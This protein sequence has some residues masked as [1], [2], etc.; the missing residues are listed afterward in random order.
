MAW[1]NLNVRRIGLPVARCISCD[2]YIWFVTFNSDILSL[3]TKCFRASQPKICCKA[4]DNSCTG[5]TFL[6]PQISA[7]LGPYFWGMAIGALPL[8]SHETHF[9]LPLTIAFWKSVRTS[10]PAWRIH[11]QTLLTGKTEVIDR[12]VMTTHFEG[13]KKSLNKQFSPIDS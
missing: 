13:K 1:S 2:T 12:K 6:Q 8:D 3:Q 7:L 11:L 9:L 5:T 4:E 10:K